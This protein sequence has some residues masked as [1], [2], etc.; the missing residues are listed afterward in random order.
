M[1]CSGCVTSAEAVLIQEQS[2]VKLLDAVGNG[3]L[4]CVVCLSPQSLASL[5]VQSKLPVVDTFLRVAGLLK[6]I[7]VEYVFDS[8]C[9]NDI[10]LIEARN[11]FF[12]R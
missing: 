12:E 11:E 2:Y 10:A 6:G 3:L 9:A 5:S 8:S 1:D 4:A 7:G